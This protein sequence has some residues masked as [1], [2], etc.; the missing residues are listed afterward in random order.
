MS[1]E[2][3]EFIELL[4]NDKDYITDSFYGYFRTTVADRYTKAFSCVLNLIEKQQKEN[5][6]LRNKLDITEKMIDEMVEH[7]ASSAIVDDMVCMYM[8]CNKEECHN[9]TA[10]K[11]TKEYFRKK[12]EK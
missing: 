10:R 7:I 8:D 12:V 5:E 3:K 1:E 11:C 9:D 4:E 2:E 6:K